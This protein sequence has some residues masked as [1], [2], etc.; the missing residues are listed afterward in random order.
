MWGINSVMLPCFYS[1]TL[2]TLNKMFLVE[3]MPPG[4]ISTSG[5]GTEWDNLFH[6]W[7]DKMTYEKMLA[8]LLPP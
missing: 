3:V 4:G 2:L 6:D 5:D 1:A 8:F 7:Q